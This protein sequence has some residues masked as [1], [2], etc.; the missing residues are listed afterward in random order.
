MS[1]KV[2][3][4]TIL[5]IH[6]Q[7]LTRQG[8]CLFEDQ[9]MCYNCTQ[10]SLTRFFKY[11]EQKYHW[12]QQMSGAEF[13]MHLHMCCRIIVAQHHICKFG[14]KSQG[15]H[16]S[17]IRWFSDT[18]LSDTESSA[19]SES[20]SSEAVAGKSVSQ[21]G[22]DV[23]ALHTPVL[24][25]PPFTPLV[26]PKIHSDEST[27][28]DSNAR[29][30]SSDEDFGFGFIVPKAQ[31]SSVPTS[32]QDTTIKSAPPE[33]QTQEES[34]DSDCKSTSSESSSSADLFAATH[35]LVTM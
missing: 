30:E 27:D 24:L 19:G 25:T 26:S 34:T 13:V 2:G 14:F 9:T 6:A 23:A 7:G 21:L 32:S 17:K 11:L 29:S 18:M 4:F 8:P 1:I 15:R 3:T 35:P 31:I 20:S 16:R 33:F 5:A 28:D 10:A 22:E 12:V